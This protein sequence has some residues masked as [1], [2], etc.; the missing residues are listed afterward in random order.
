MLGCHFL[1]IF[2]SLV[3]RYFVVFLSFFSVF[4]KTVSFFDDFVGRMKLS[5]F[6]HFLV[7]FLSFFDFLSF[8][9]KPYHFL[10]ICRR[11]VAKH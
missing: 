10:M 7:I 5:S 4:R 3:C 2:L 11:N 8:F 1:V 6:C 9:E